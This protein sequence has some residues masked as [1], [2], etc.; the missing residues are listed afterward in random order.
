[1]SNPTNSAR[2]PTGKRL[3]VALKPDVNQMLEKLAKSSGMTLSEA[4]QKAIAT[5]FY[6][7]EE[8]EQG[9]KILVRKPNDEI[10]QVVFR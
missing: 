3:T 10:H 4:I 1:M 7:R 2:P 9:S 6:I 5:E 8:I